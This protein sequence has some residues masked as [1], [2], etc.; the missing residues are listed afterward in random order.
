[1]VDIHGLRC[2]YIMLIVLQ[3]LCKQFTECHTCISVSFL[4]HS[5]INQFENSENVIQAKLYSNLPSL[6][7]A[8]VFL[9]QSKGQKVLRQQILNFIL[10]KNPR[11]A[12]GPTKIKICLV[13]IFFPQLPQMKP[14]GLL[15]FGIY[16]QNR[17]H[18]DIWWDALERG[19]S[20]LK[21]PVYT[22]EH[23]YI[24]KSQSNLQ[25]DLG[26]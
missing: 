12:V 13:L 22:M 8:S 17:N 11:T 6:F 19:S 25:C 1:V 2:A 7:L 5:R 15:L 9:T 20:Y 23:G 26:F 10:R 16:S 3:C 14:P 18:L 24:A 4:K 21:A